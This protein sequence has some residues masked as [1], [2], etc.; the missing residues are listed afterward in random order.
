MNALPPVILADAVEMAISIAILA[1]AFIGWIVQ[2]ASSNKPAT[3]PARAR[4]NR[5]AGNHAAGNR[6]AGPANRPRSR[7]DRLQSEIDAFLRD[8]SGNRKQPADDDDVAIEIIPDSELPPEP[9]RR[10]E[11]AARSS[12]EAA[13]EPTYAEA[14][15]RPVVADSTVSE[16]DLEQQRRRERLLSGPAGRHLPSG[17]LG[18]EIRAHVEEYMAEQSRRLEQEKEQA[19][20]QLAAAQ[21]EINKLRSQG[22]SLRQARQE[23]ATIAVAIRDPGSVAVL[24]RNPTTLRN[25][26][27]INEVLTRPVALR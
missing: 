12:T 5:P 23:A 18:E 24:L 20:R 2:M 11:R 3:P 8:V 7:D 10:L 19:Q 13:A 16:W 9:V 26:I 14:T 1:I 21:D 27:V 25:A 22:S 4:P 17:H 15:A 6:A